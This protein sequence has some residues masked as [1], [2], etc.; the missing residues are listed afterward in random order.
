[1]YL[2]ESAAHEEGQDRVTGSETVVVRCSIGRWLS[3]QSAPRRNPTLQSQKSSG[4]ARLARQ[5]P[6]DRFSWPV[7]REFMPSTH[8]DWTA[9]LLCDRPTVEYEA[10]EFRLALYRASTKVTFGKEDW[11]SE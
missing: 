9:L 2:R 3:N 5:Q 8:L 6:D 1:M 7:L 4:L 10:A 11:K